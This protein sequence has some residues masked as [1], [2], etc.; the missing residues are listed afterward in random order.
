MKE[1]LEEEKKEERSAS[2]RSEAE[3][4]PMCEESTR[5]SESAEEA[6][7][8]CRAKEAEYPMK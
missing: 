6:S 2:T 1:E 8:N 5:D 7:V 4:S 3:W